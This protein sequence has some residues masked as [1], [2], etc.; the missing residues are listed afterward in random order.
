MI[1]GRDDL[2][3]G[4]LLGDLLSA[5]AAL[6]WT[7]YSV[8]AKPLLAVHPPL[9]ITALA[10]VL[11]TLPLLLI[12]GPALLAVEWGSLGPGTWLLL[13]YLSVG[14]IV[15]ASFL[16]FWALARAST[17]RV[18][19]YSYLTPVLAAGISVALGQDAPSV[20]LAVGSLAVVAGVALT[21]LG[22]R[23]CGR[24]LSGGQ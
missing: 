14:T 3:G 7:V 13:A 24:R 4:T 9:Q 16:W 17:A 22:L 15:V 11:G 2:T 6:A 18:A 23:E 12:G 8:G 5:G 10:M 1:I 19:A 20:S 21:Q